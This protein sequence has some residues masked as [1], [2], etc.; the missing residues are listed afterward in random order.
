MEAT[1]VLYI[2]FHLKEGDWQLLIDIFQRNKDFS[3][4]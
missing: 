2:F 4:S 1:I 3:A